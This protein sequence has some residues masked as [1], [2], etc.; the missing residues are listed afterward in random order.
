MNTFLQHPALRLTYYVQWSLNCIQHYAMCVSPGWLHEVQWVLCTAFWTMNGSFIRSTVLSPKGQAQEWQ[1]SSDSNLPHKLYN[2]VHLLALPTLALQIGC[3][4]QIF[5]PAPIF[6]AL[7]NEFKQSGLFKQQK[8]HA[9]G[10]D[11]PHMWMTDILRSQSLSDEAW[12][13]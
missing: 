10:A 2:W 6:L 12:S 13:C 5:L 11:F 4:K 9:S 8:D 7:H 3:T 1:Q